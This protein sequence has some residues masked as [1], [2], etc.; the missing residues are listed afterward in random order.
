MADAYEPDPRQ[1]RRAIRALER[2]F[3][4]SVMPYRFGP[5]LRTGWP[6]AFRCTDV[7]SGSWIECRWSLGR[8]VVLT[9]H[10]GE[11]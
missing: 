1:R 2:R 9:E 10:D 4:K 5:S 8:L 11:S 6:N 3:G 7:E